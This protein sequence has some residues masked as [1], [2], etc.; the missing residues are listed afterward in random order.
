MGY[1]AAKDYIF[2][3]T[4]GGSGWIV[5]WESSQELLS[6]YIFLTHARMNNL[7]PDNVMKLKILELKC[8]CG[9]NFVKISWKLLSLN[10]SIYHIKS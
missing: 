2:L 1:D 10:R 8:A 5:I 6:L 9:S 4:T 3:I 7:L